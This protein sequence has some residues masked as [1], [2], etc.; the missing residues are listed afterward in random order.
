MPHNQKIISWPALSIIFFLITGSG[1][2]ASGQ[3]LQD[4]LTVKKKIIQPEHSP[5]KALILAATLPG[6]GQAYNRKYWKIPIAYAGYAGGAY[7]F[8]TNQ[9][10]YKNAKRDY[11]F[12]TD[13]I[14][15]TINLSGKS[16]PVLLNEVD[17]YRRMRDIS[18]LVLLAWHGLTIIDANVDAH[19]FN[20]DVNE[21]LSISMKPRALWAGIK[22]PGLGLSVVINLK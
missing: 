17:Y 1:Y 22:N 19:F 21:D 16:A 7:F 8:Y 6:S 5:R 10:S 20:W 9:K 14:D 15:S 12:E 4:T 11:I 2:F 13:K 18:V 3:N